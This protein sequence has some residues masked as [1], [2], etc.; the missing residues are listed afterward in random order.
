MPTKFSSFAD[1]T[2]GSKASNFVEHAR[3]SAA[4]KKRQDSLLNGQASRN[5]DG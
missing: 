4:L 1:F 5:I 3:H 2:R